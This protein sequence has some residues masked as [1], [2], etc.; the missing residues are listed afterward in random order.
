[1]GV[2]SD[3]GGLYLQEDLLRV[4]AASGSAAAPA[5]TYTSWTPFGEPQGSPA[6]SQYLS[7]R[8]A[9]GW[10]TENVSPFGFLRNPLEPPY[11]AF[12]PDLSLAAFVTDE[13]PLASG[14][15]EDSRNLYL[16]DDGSGG[17]RCLTTEKPQFT[18]STQTELDKLCVGFAGASADGSRAF[19]AADGAYAAT[20]APAGVGFS[21]YESSL[22]EGLK[23]VSV[24]PNGTPAPPTAA[25]VSDPGT[26]FGAVGARCAI[27][28]GA[29]AGAVSE[30]GTRVFWS[31]GGT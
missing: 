17:L 10:Q 23:L 28:Q 3:A 9:S 4:V 20:G 13:P 22:A 24:L 26:G 27:D 25:T 16:R 29:L 30:D 18:P 6:A 15:Q 21:L 7:T 5:I 31:Y 14:C 1:M 12:S 2:P 11:R 8:T 19:F